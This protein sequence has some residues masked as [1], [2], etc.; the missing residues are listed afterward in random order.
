M[1]VGERM[2]IIRLSE[3]LAANKDYAERI[4]VSVITRKVSNK[5]RNNTKK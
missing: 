3:K 1:G 2:Q 4:G 5:E